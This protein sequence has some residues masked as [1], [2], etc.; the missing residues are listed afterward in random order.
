[1]RQT[2]PKEAPKIA[3]NR[4][5]HGFVAERT[6]VRDA[7][8]LGL[9][10]GGDAQDRGDAIQR[11]GH[12][13]VVEDLHGEGGHRGAPR[14]PPVHRRR[15]RDGVVHRGG[16]RRR[17]WLVPATARRRRHLRLHRLAISRVSSCIRTRV[18]R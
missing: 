8:A 1:M 13:L 2:V 10:L 18:K 14:P 9:D 7:G 6:E 4:E 12:H 15:G 5:G 17:R 3:Q 11:G 16:R